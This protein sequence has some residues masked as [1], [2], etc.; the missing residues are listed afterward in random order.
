[1]LSTYQ[2]TSGVV[3]PSVG[4]AGGGES[5]YGQRDPLRVVIRHQCGRQGADARPAA[6]WLSS[7]GIDIEFADLSRLVLIPSLL[8]TANSWHRLAASLQSYAWQASPDVEL[9]PAQLEKIESAWRYFLANPACAAM[10]PG[11]ALLNKRAIRQ[12]SLGQAAGLVSA[13]AVMPYPPG[14]PI[15]APG[16]I[17][18]DARVDFLRQ[19]SENEINISGIDQ[20]QVWVL[21]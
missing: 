14:I 1:M 13:R 15:I 8:K 7:Q 2:P 21:A 16:E 18:D 11:E 12:V 4:P 17:I 6:R 19:L 9:D 5:Q 20:S 10:S 3:M